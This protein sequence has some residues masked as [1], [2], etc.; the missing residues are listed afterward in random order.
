M[1]PVAG[2]LTRSLVAAGTLAVL[3]AAAGCQPVESE[4]PPA[5]DVPAGAIDG[6]GGTGTAGD[7]GTLPSDVPTL[8]ADLEQTAAE[9]QPE[10]VIVEV[11]IALDGE[12]W[13]EASVTYLAPDADRMLLVQADAEG[14]RQQRPT[15]ET[16]DL[17][18]VAAAGL[19][20]V[21]PLPA[22]LLEPRALVEGA[23]EALEECSTGEV[24]SVLYSSG[25][26]AAWDGAAWTEPPAW[27]ATLAGPD[28]GLVVDPVT[29]DALPDGC[30]AAG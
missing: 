27:A 12:R 14:T 6:D 17:E 1:L 22:G 8:L 23:G 13:R 16:L 21:P 24:R 19:A 20:E 5:E 4:V 3:A 28:G 7:T 2:I 11:A 18:P 26:P 25:A 29:A 9:W 30:L 15:L 10:T